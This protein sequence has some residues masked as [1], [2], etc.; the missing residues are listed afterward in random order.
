MKMKTKTAP[1]NCES[2]EMRR[3]AATVPCS[4]TQSPTST[5]RASWSCFAGSAQW[6]PP[7]GLLGAQKIRRL[8]LLCNIGGSERQRINRGLR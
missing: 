8:P 2:L 4:L 6:L 7:A 5:R 3:S 1:A